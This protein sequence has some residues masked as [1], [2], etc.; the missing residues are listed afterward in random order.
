MQKLTLDKDLNEVLQY[1]GKESVI[2]VVN[3]AAQIPVEGIYEIDDLF[4]TMLEN[5][6]KEHM[7]KD[8]IVYTKELSNTIMFNFEDSTLAIKFLQYVNA[9]KLKQS[10]LYYDMRV[11]YTIQ[12][13]LQ[14]NVVDT[15]ENLSYKKSSKTKLNKVIQSKA[16][17]SI[18]IN[19]TTRNGY[20]FGAKIY[21]NTFTQPTQN[22]HVQTGVTIEF[23]SDS[24]I[25]ENNT[26]DK[27][28]IGVLFTPRNTDSVQRIRISNNLFTSIGRD[29]LGQGGAVFFNNS[30]TQY[31]NGIRIYN[32]TFLET[33]KIR[34]GMPI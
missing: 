33:I 9:M 16:K 5:F 12:K 18:D 28:S 25:V 15:E 2:N 11:L 1:L 34:S 24:V 30:A 22:T 17:S 19:H 26:F 27:I 7:T 23:E 31:V 29:D 20:A 10:K 13:Q 32:N 8:D 3:N 14:T 21:N 6:R 4:P